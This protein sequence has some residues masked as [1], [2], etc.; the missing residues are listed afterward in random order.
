MWMT[1][2]RETDPTES[3]LSTE[4]APRD[5]EPGPRAEHGPTAQPA[6]N[7]TGFWKAARKDVMKDHRDG[8]T[9]ARARACTTATG[10]PTGS[11][12]TNARL[13]QDRRP[14]CHRVGPR[15]AQMVSLLS[16]TSIRQT[17]PVI[18][19][20]SRVSNTRT[21]FSTIRYGVSSYRSGI[22]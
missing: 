15:T 1:W 13:R 6:G 19:S 22:R 14:A 5:A 8:T 2:A 12:E 21:S 10:G 20:G 16:A 18:P 9:S 4:A 7:V 17:S 3:D 11:G